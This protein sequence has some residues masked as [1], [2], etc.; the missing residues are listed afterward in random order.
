MEITTIP[1]EDQEYLPLSPN[2][3]SPPL[4]TRN[5][6]RKKSTLGNYL[7]QADQVY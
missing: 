2:S 7:R 1:K 3:E 6:R 4:S 5:S